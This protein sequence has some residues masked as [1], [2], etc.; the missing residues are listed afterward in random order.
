[1]ATAVPLRFVDRPPMKIPTAA[2]L[3]LSVS[4][5]CG[6]AR[7]YVVR[8]NNGV[9]L[10]AAS[11]PKLKNGYYVFK[12]ASGREAYIPQGRVVEVAPAGRVSEENSPFR[13]TQ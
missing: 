2:M 10:T 7:H 9:R 13:Q 12:D 1:M 4:M 8:M 11:K 5:L 6:C 3:V